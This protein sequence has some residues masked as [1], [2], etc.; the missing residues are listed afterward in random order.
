MDSPWDIIGDHDASAPRRKKVLHVPCI[1]TDPLITTI[2][3][4]SWGNTRGSDG[5]RNMVPGSP[6]QPAAKGQL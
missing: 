5:H 4:K 3:R 1:P 6:A 2:I